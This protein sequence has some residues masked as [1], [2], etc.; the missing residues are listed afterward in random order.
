MAQPKKKI[1]K[2]TRRVSRPT[3]PSAKKK[4]SGKKSV[5]KKKGSSTAFFSQEVLP[6]PTEIK[7]AQNNA[8]LLW[9]AAVI[10]IIA[11]WMVWNKIRN[12]ESLPPA[13]SVATTEPVVSSEA[14]IEKN[15][16]LSQPQRRDAGA[17]ALKKETKTA[18]LTPKKKSSEI[19][20]SENLLTFSHLKKQPV[21]FEVTRN[22]KEKAEIIIFASGNRNVRMLEV[23]KGPQA[24]ITLRWNGTDAQGNPV[25]A[26]LYWA[27]V[28]DADGHRIEEIWVDE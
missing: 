13:R 6:S 14:V 8:W 23:E 24:V 18:P 22:P 27:R 25:K 16:Q 19:K 5:S 4:T 9:V 20:A 11:G 10:I 28:T 26:G 12:C 7:P 1:K 21:A 15:S 17:P 3:S 2:T